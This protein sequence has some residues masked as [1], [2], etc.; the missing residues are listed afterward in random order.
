MDSRVPL[1]VASALT[2]ALLSGCIVDSP[3]FGS[4]D[5]E[6]RMWVEPMD[7]EIHPGVTTPVWAFCAEGDGV[8]PVFGD[9][10]CSVP[11]P[12]IR[13]REGDRIRLSF[14][15]THAIPHTV[16]F[17]GWHE[18]AADMNGNG[19]LGDAMVADPGE[20][21]V[22]EWVA[23]PAG[24]FIYH[25]HF[26]TPTHMDMGMYGAF[27]VEERFGDKPDVDVP[28]VLDEWQIREPGEATANGNMPAYNFFTINGKSFPLTQPIIAERGDHVRLHIVNAGY[29]I[30][31]MHLHGFTPDAWEGVAGPKA[32][33]RTDV[34]MIAP[35]QTVVFDFEADRE[36]AWLMHDHVVPRVTA[37][38]DGSGGFGAYPRGMLTV[39]LVGQEYVDAVVAA[40][41]DLIQA[42][43][44]DAAGGKGHD[45]DAHG[46]GGEDEADAPTDGYTSAMKDLKFEEE[47]RITA[48]TTVTWV[49]EDSF[50]HTVTADDGSFDSGN[51]AGGASWSYTFDEPGT[52]PYYCVPHSWQEDGA[53]KGMTGVVIVE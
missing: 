39:L 50:G 6:I 32:A 19:I 38:N 8:E 48:G 41:P 43:E 21:E 37:G 26:D 22:I 27:I 24:S 28:L 5:R 25:C 23:E 40:V 17:H 30:H 1:L 7:W 16:H 36:G 49:N 42:A 44:G 33:F 15:N 31:A 10:A 45:H 13:V 3:P 11:A 47:I 34:R 51:V 4:V 46:D 12:T 53:W 35:G 29:E 52:Y 9:A 20:T 14:E 2:A 18:F